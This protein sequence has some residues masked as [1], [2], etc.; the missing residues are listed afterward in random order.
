MSNRFFIII[1]SIVC[2]ISIKYFIEFYSFKEQA[3][4]SY[5]STNKLVQALDIVKM[6]EFM[7]FLGW[8]IILTLTLSFIAYFN[9][10]KYK[11]N[12]YGYQEYIWVPLVIIFLNLLFVVIFLT[13]VLNWLIAILLTAIVAVL[14]KK[15]VVEA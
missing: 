3:L 4:E 10:K 1:D 14:I 5:S 12:D 9:Y 6:P 11:A 8:G 13:F 15:F 2:I 7:P